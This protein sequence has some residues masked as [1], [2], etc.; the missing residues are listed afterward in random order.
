MWYLEDVDGET[1]TH[2]NIRFRNHFKHELVIGGLIDHL[3]VTHE[4][5]PETLLPLRGHKHSFPRGR[6]FGSTLYRGAWEDLLIPDAKRRVLAAFGRTTQDMSEVNDGHWDPS[7]ETDPDH[8]Q[9]SGGCRSR[10]LPPHV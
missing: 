3:A 8:C 10:R 4:L 5:P 7:L 6:V 2:R 9:I 1:E